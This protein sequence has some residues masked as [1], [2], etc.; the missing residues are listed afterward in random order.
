ML[1]VHC[2]RLSVEKKPERS[3]EAL[4][5]LRARG[6]PAVLVVVGDGPLRARLVRRA[7]GLP[8]GCS[9]CRERWPGP[10]PAGCGR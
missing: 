10:W 1:L 3:V 5:A 7:A 4:A 6:V 2:G 9:A 8:G